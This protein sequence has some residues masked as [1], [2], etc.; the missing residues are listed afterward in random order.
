MS[1]FVERLGV[2]QVEQRVVSDDDLLELPLRVLHDVHRILHDDLALG[3]FE[4]D[5][6]AVH[7]NSLTAGTRS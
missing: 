7:S 3:G 2:R 5:A 6:V 4:E 1:V